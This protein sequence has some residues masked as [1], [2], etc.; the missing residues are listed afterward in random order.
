MINGK[1]NPAYDDVHVNG[2]PNHRVAQRRGF[3]RQA[4]AGADDHLARIQ[5]LLRGETTFVASAHGFSPQFAAVD[6]GS[7][8]VELGLLSK[9]QTS[10]RRPATGETIGRA[11]ACG[12]GGAVQI[13]LNIEGRDPAR[14]G[15][16]Q[17][18]QP[19]RRRPSRR[20]KQRSSP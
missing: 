4:Y 15:L 20:S 9:P 2:T 19:T 10:N 7:V 17:W 18:R 3:L 11:K 8:L 14:G 6:A 12:A 1:L 5:K 13:Y 16:N